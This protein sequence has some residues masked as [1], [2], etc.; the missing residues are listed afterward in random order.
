MGYCSAEETARGG[1][2]KKYS[3]LLCIYFEVYI[4]IRRVLRTMIYTSVHNKE[5]V[6][7]Q[8]GKQRQNSL[9]T[10]ITLPSHHYL[11]L[12]H[13]YHDN[14]ISPSFCVTSCVSRVHLPPGVTVRPGASARRPRVQLFPLPSPSVVAVSTR[15]RPQQIPTAPALFHLVLGVFLRGGE[16]AVV[17]VIVG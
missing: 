13:N 15:V 10:T 5:G 9:T 1:D 6:A 4:Y 16:A 11:T 8:R 12:T 2:N 17:V 14:T 7:S 3:Y